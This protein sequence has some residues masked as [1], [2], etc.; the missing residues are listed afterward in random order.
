[1]ASAA[2]IPTEWS[3]R[4]SLKA[5]GPGLMRVALP[6]ATFDAAKP[7]L[8]DLRVI[9]ATGREVPYLLE[10]DL[11]TPGVPA[12][13]RSP[14]SFRSHPSGDTTLMVFETGISGPIDAIALETPTPFFLKAAH[15]E[16][17]PDGESW[18]SLGAAVPVFR[19]FG[20]EQ[21]RLVLGR[22]PA[23]FIRVTLD[24]FHSRHVD[25]TGAMVLPGPAYT[26]LPVLAPLGAH[27][28][29]RDEF[30]GETVLTV[31]LD[32]RHV[33]LA[34]LT[35]QAQDPLFMRRVTVA[36]REVHDAVSSE[37]IV[38]SGTIY[39]VALD[40]VPARA[41]LDVPMDFLPQTRE[42]LVHIHNGDS[43]PL[44]LDGVSASQHPAKL[45]FVA[46][47]AES[48]TLLSGNPQAVM[49]R[50]DLAVFAGE[51]NMANATPVV[52]GDVEEMPNYHPRESL[53]E[54]PLPD[55]P[56]TGAP[57][58]TKD[59]TD[60]RVIAMEHAGVQELE[61]D[62]AAL[63][64][65]RAD[66]GDLRLVR[67]GN[68][69][70]YV[71]E[72]PALARSLSLQTTAA[73]ES[74]RPSVSIWQLRLPQSGPPLRRLILNSST[75]LF[76]REFRI[77]EKL[78]TA[79]GHTYE[80][81]L[82]SGTWSRTP[83]P[84][85]PETRIF[86]LTDRP[87]SDTL[88]IETDNGDNPAIALGAVQVVYPV[89]RLI[90]KT[91]ETDGFALIYGNPTAGTPRYDLNL[92]AVKLLT[93]SRNVARL[94]DQPAAAVRSPF[95]GINGGYIFWGALVLVVVVLLTVVAKLLPKPPA[96]S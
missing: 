88:W 50:Y 83:E 15:V 35:L 64:R 36:V 39:R 33:L 62:F 74:K 16:I 26:P 57:L 43:P 80:N 4:Q 20:A 23:A 37:R 58:D 25:F 61:L 59:W 94:A 22:R 21:L 96:A 95:R 78:S 52:P 38:G 67:G 85:V 53:A 76:Q 47:A 7:M 90:F 68:Q 73:P 5:T 71:I 3:H 17:S 19:Q 77:Y 66:Y 1:M 18:M 79:E 44:T 82:A 65:S 11:F 14:R 2:V 9:D 69:I 13:W 87:R 6:V 75:P 31:A 12:Q 30:A 56:L 27:I 72:V 45:L 29:R 54:T 55:V 48:Y 93:S 60:R 8:S 92:V 89:V 70:P 46:S 51:M 84:G 86:D 42:L 10:Y 41:Q 34:G 32:G 28:T 81:V 91:A 49:P 40:G 63:A 24:D